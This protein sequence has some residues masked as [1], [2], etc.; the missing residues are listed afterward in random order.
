M[1]I[2]TAGVRKARKNHRYD[3]EKF[4]VIK[5]LQAIEGA[6]TRRTVELSMRAED[7]RPGLSL[8]GFILSIVGAHS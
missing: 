5:T 7:L 2:D 1:L 6:N 4:S 3:E 8:L